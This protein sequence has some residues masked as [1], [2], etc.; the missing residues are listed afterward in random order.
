M[1]LHD[2]IED[3]LR[4]AMKVRDRATMDALRMLKSALTNRAVADGGTP[5]SRLDDE[6]VMA[7]VATEVKRRREAATAFRDGGREESALKEEAE[8]AVYAAYLPA[9]MDDAALRALVAAA[10]TR[11]GATGPRDAGGVIR[12]VLAEASGG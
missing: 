4:A 11:L 6:T 5:T 10:A 3:D 9:Q 7:A 1:S 12:E 2:R 8:A